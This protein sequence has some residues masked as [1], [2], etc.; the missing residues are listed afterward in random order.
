MKTGRF[1][2]I[3]IAFLLIGHAAVA[4]NL[5]TNNSFEVP[6]LNNPPDWWIQDSI[7]GWNTPVQNLGFYNAGIVHSNAFGVAYAADGRQWVWLINT[8]EPGY[9]AYQHPIGTVTSNQDYLVDFAF[10]ANASA[11]ARQVRVQ[12]FGFDGVSTWTE[13]AFTNV[14]G[15]EVALTYENKQVTINTGTSHIGE[16][17]YF[18]FKWQSGEQVLLDNVFVRLPGF[19]GSMIVIR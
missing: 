13:I 15:P 5:V 12:L 6:L 17:L 7:A 16:E 14:A 4:V 9:V 18:V 1:A 8:T 19:L 2:A 11:G 10:G 3:T